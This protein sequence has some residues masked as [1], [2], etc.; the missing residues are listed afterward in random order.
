MDE[1]DLRSIIGTIAWASKTEEEARQPLV[2]A[3]K[4]GMSGH[5]NDS[6]FLRCLQRLDERSSVKLLLKV[7]GP[8]VEFVVRLLLVA[9]F[10]DDSFRAATHF[11]E[12]I[13]Q[14]GEMG[15]LSGLFKTQPELV[16]AIAT[17]ALG[18]G[19]LAQSLGSVC[20][21][22]LVLPDL[23]TKA[24]IG[25]AIAQPVLYAQLAN[26]EFVAESLTLV[27]GLLILRAHLSEQQAKRDV[28]LLPGG[29]KSASD[30]AP[31]EAAIAMT[32]LLGRL[33]LPSLYLFRAGHTLHALADA[34]WRADH[35]VPMFVVSAAV[36]AG[37][38]LGCGLVAF[39]LKSR[40]VALSLAVLNLLFM[41][42]QH[43]IFLFVWREGGEWKYDEEAM[44]KAMPHVALPQDNIPEDFEAWHLADLHRYYFFQGLSA[45]GALLLLAQFGPGELAVE[46]DEVILGEVQTAR[47]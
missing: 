41:C 3:G 33:L 1:L 10:L 9:T 24:L 30:A 15:Y 40:T 44:R 42:Y 2:H 27:G 36:L 18:I 22:A 34:Q 37:L 35:S 39:G 13:D 28:P 12:H 16:G 4:L 17:I 26:F 20:L 8:R 21:L 46:K 32:Q 5:A 45:T 23:A 11:Y 6:I 14:V 19:L 31:G 25:W 7:W 38:V 47:D 43:P 29:A